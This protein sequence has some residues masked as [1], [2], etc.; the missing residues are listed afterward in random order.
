ML[1]RALIVIAL[2]AL[3]ALQAVRVAAVRADPPGW[4]A[5]LWASHPQVALHALMSEIGR[6]AARGEGLTPEM[7]AQVDAVAARAPLAP[8][9][10]L[11]KAAVAQRDGR[12]EQAERLFVEARKRDPRSEAARYFLADR[13]LRSGR[14]GDAL[15]E[16]LV[17]ARLIP[18]A[19]TQFA[20]ALAS[21]AQTP[22]A[23]PELRRFFRAS[24]DFEPLV[25]DQLAAN[26][27]NARLALA[28]WSGGRARP[29]PGVPDWKARL[30]TG[31][32]EQRRFAEARSVWSKLSGMSVP[33]DEIFNPQFAKVAAPAPFNWSFPTL[34]GVAEPASGGR[35]SVIY[36][37]RQDAILADQLLSLPAGRYRLAM[38]VSGGTSEQSVVSWTLNCVG[39][40]PTLVDLPLGRESARRRI[41]AQFAV[42]AGCPAQRLQ[43]KGSAGE[44]SRSAEFTI[45]A[46][47]LQRAGS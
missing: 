19:S 11:I 8:E 10:F 5:R 28:L 39:N 7:L 32:V 33:P 37:G 34:G 40:G 2:S 31:L 46:L 38:T 16:I 4:G 13:Y 42:P 47:Q 25:L 44:F 35:L 30:V 20:P 1:I 45:E 24:P 22:G 26:P 17:L 9:P 41:G 23:V 6:R 36:F 3:L 21:F 12:E 15:S 27:S 43:L 29:G 14:T 18:G